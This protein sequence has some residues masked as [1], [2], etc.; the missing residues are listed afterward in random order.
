[1]TR[2]TIALVGGNWWPR[3]V[4]QFGLAGFSCEQIQ[5]ELMEGRVYN[6]ELWT[7]QR[8]CQS[9][10]QG[11]YRRGLEPSLSLQI[12]VF[13]HSQATKVEALAAY[14]KTRGHSLTLLLTGKWQKLQ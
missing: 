14:C 2:C 12:W 13:L 7:E 10:A 6:E 5:A 1:M 4:L 8:L 3:E 11:P 9:A